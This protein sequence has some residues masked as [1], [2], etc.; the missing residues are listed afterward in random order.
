MAALLGRGQPFGSVKTKGPSG[1]GPGL[2]SLFGDPAG[3]RT[4]N[5]RLKSALRGKFARDGRSG[6]ICDSVRVVKG[7]GPRCDV[8]GV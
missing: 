8:G 5:T 4:Q 6:M 2:V 3:S 1:D 7:L